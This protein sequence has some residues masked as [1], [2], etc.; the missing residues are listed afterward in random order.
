MRPLRTSGYGGVDLRL[1]CYA[2]ACRHAARLPISFRARRTTA[3]TPSAAA[4]GG[5]PQPFAT[6]D[7][8]RYSGPRAAASGA[9]DLLKKIR[10]AGVAG[11]ISFGLV[12]TAFWAASVPVCLLV[13]SLVSG[14]WP[15]FSDSEDLATFG[16]EAFAFVNIARLAAPLRIGAALSAVPWVQANIVDKLQL[17]RRDFGTADPDPNRSPPPRR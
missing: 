2:L 1:S 9:K 8:N 12:Q 15:D 3:H 4:Y 5:A 11:V 6:D 13:Y 17:W 14:H 7:E 10:D 16:A